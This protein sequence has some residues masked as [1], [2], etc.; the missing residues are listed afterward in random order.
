MEKL[1]SNN[2]RMSNGVNTLAWKCCANAKWRVSVLPKRSIRKREKKKSLYK[3]RNGRNKWKDPGVSLNRGIFEV[4]NIFPF[5]LFILLHR[6]FPALSIHTFLWWLV[7]STRTSLHQRI[8][9]LEGA[10]QSNVHQVYMEFQHL[11]LQLGN[12]QKKK[13]AIG[14]CE[15][16][17]SDKLIVQN[18]FHE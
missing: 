4:F 12:R 7:P 17:S 1:C 5:H 11:Y 18:N 10:S 14:E 16:S 15:L 9:I 3:V 8:R 6:L 2:V 13:T